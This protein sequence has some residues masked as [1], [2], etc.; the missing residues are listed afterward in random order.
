M[1]SKHS[2]LYNI[3]P[4]GIGTMEVECLT[5]Y[6]ARIAYAHCVETG[7]L[8]NEILIPEIKGEGI[9]KEESI[10][11]IYRGGTS[12]FNGLSVAADKNANIMNR[13]CGRDDL[14]NLTIIKYK[15]ILNDNKLLKKNKSWCPYCLAD[16][17]EVQYEKLIWSIM[18]VD[19]CHIHNVKLEETCRKCGA[20]QNH[21]KF[22]TLN[23]FCQK[24]SHWLG[25]IEKVQHGGNESNSKKVFIIGNLLKDT[26]NHDLITNEY[27][28]KNLIL[29]WDLIP[30][31]KREFVENNIGV[32]GKLLS[33]FQRGLKDKISLSSLIRLCTF[34]NCSTNDILDRLMD[35]SFELLIKN[36]KLVF[37]NTK[38]KLDIVKLEKEL[39]EYLNSCE[40]DEKN[41]LS[42]NELEKKI[43]HVGSTI[44]KYFP[45]LYENIKK[46]NTESR[47]K[48]KKEKQKE[49]MELIRQETIK[50]YQSGIYPS[51]RRVF[52]KLPFVV[53]GFEK[54]YRDMWEAT[55]IELGIA[56]RVNQYD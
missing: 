42:I 48:L 1:R 33:D 5:S 29:L 46:Q 54:E 34:F 14:E 44:K 51:L 25:N 19:I 37:K 40:K 21:L 28:I 32:Q 27:M 56:R 20:L 31:P 23:G 8:I 49:R 39:I 41:Y 16:M 3:P 45:V 26:R 52:S 17:K 36:E 35:I 7:T 43:G 4:I 9:Y 47:E 10:F 24:C 50:L 15:N 55:I 13:L 11:A 2:V 6:I 30:S 12:K 38:R 53:T 22:K 18:E